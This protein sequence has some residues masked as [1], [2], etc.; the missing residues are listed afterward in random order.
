MKATINDEADMLKLDEF[1]DNS[2]Y[3]LNMVQAPIKEERKSN[4]PILSSN[5]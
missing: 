4:L 5:D 3:H 2:D 1:V